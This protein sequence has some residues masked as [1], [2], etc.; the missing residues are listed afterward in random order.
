MNKHKFQGVCRYLFRQ[1]TRSTLK[2]ILVILVAFAIFFTLGWLQETIDRNEA[3]IARLYESTYVFGQLLPRDADARLEQ[4]AGFGFIR[5]STAD[6]FDSSGLLLEV[7]YETSFPLAFV[8]GT[9]VIVRTAA[10]MIPQ[11][12]IAIDPSIGADN[13]EELA[14]YLNLYI[15]DYLDALP[16]P[17]FISQDNDIRIVRDPDLAG[18]V[19]FDESK[20]PI[21]DLLD[22]MVSDIRNIHNSIFIK[23]YFVYYH[24]EF[25]GAFPR[26]YRRDSLRFQLQ[27]HH[28]YLDQ[29]IAV[30]CLDFLIE[31]Q[32]ANQ[33]A[34]EIK[35]AS[36]FDET[37][38]IY[39]AGANLPIPVILSENM[40]SRYGLM[41]GDLMTLN[42]FYDF[43]V[44]LG[45]TSYLWEQLSGVVIG[46]HNYRSL[47]ETAFLPIEAWRSVIEAN[48]PL[49]TVEFYIDPTLNREIDTVRA[50][51]ENYFSTASLMLDIH[52]EELRFVVQTM[53]ENVS[54]LW[55]LY[56]VVITVSLM[57]ASAASFFLTLQNAKN[58]AMMR[59]FGITRRKAGL[60]LWVEQT[61]LCLIGLILGLGLLIAFDWGFGLLGLFSVAGLYLLSVMVGSIIG[62]MLIVRQSP[63]ELLQVKE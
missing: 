33:G 52:D 42:Y 20:I 54:L 22:E 12:Y 57:I 24:D 30:S 3:E 37:A 6:R 35:F 34:F 29:V 44:A 23:R 17:A 55:L 2:S 58:V 5:R 60:I 27:Y 16:E 46:M 41:L 48:L 39:E 8:T 53:E 14:E 36:G 4:E 63:L 9:D 1:M 47:K 7:Y 21:D 51:L 62:I 26:N 45:F 50:S 18:I 25:L 49:S 38:F 28:Y 10:E 13:L 40:M 31:R 32:I 59:V 61:I 56:P 11:I 43:F 19:E 15:L